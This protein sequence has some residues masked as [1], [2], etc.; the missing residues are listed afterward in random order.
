MSYVGQKKYAALGKLLLKKRPEVASELMM[1]LNSDS[2]ETRLDLIPQYFQTYCRIK[3]IDPFNCTGK[4][5]THAKMRDRRVFI[6]AILVMYCK[7]VYQQP[8]DQLVLP[9]GIVKKLEKCLSI[10]K[11]YASVIIRQVINE[12][13]IYE[14]F[15]EEVTGIIPVLNTMDHGKS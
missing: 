8:T 2:S 12:H 15:R 11:A 14:D 10:S 13:R 4:L 9:Y 5:D 6:A 1:Y 3:N 7:Q